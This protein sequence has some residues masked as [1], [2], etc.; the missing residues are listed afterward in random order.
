MDQVMDNSGNRF[1][2]LRIPKDGDC[3]FGSIIHQVYGMTPTDHLFQHYKRQLREAA[4][5]ELIG[6]YELYVDQ[7]V[8]FA[9]ELI[10]GEI[11]TEIKVRRYLEKM[12]TDGEWVG[13]DCIAAICNHHQ[14]AIT[15]YQDNGKI[16]FIPT[17]SENE[18]W[19]AYKI[20]YR[21]KVNGIRT[22]Y[23]SVLSVRPNELPPFETMDYEIQ[24]VVLHNRTTTVSAVQIGDVNQSIFTA[25]HHQ[26]THR[27]PTEAELI[28]YRGLIA[29]ELERQSDSFL[30]SFGI[31]ERSDADFDAFLFNLR[32]G[33]NDG[34]FVTLSIMSSLF[35][36]KIY[37]HS[38]S[39]VT[40]RVLPADGRG[41][42]VLNIF[43]AESD[44]HNSY[45]SIVSIEHLSSSASLLPH[46]RNLP[47]PLVIASK[48]ARSEQTA[49][50][51]T[52][53]TEVLINPT[54]GLRL[55][56]LNVN[57]CRTLGKRD[58]I[59]QYLLSQHVHVAAL[60]EV[61]L[62]CLNC[63]T[64]NYIWYMGATTGNRK[65]GLAV[66]LRRGLDVHLQS[67]DNRGAYIQYL[68]LSY[69]V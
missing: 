23:D 61:N 54:H 50:Q 21:D 25:L 47:D 38:V 49:S 13:A 37:I 24:R 62:D 40:D 64:A 7:I 45:A 48:V 58:E 57:G 66:L 16:E 19:P 63:V 46:R 18:S 52:V 29:S 65:R 15:V 43:E 53:V 56:S 59:D 11:P 26:L 1:W 4:V 10:A 27:M 12:W 14:I 67:S 51:E 35:K 20:F 55:A 17:R 8:A 41:S 33:R 9:E 28:I 5:N 42:V 30:V 31:P 2:L 34:G 44:N 3:L 68:K 39:R 36:L 60:Q 6:S 69:K 32:I 22:H